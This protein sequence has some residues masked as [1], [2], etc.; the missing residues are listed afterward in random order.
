MKV[1]KLI[2]YLEDDKLP[3][4][5]FILK[6]ICFFFVSSYAGLSLNIFLLVLIFINHNEYKHSKR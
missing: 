2:K 6:V 3:K 4:T 5:K 1:Y